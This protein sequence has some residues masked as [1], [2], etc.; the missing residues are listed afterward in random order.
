MCIST[1]ILCVSLYVNLFS[2]PVTPHT[3]STPPLSHGVPGGG[4][5]AAA[6]ETDP[7]QPGAAEPQQGPGYNHN[8]DPDHDYDHNQDYSH[9]INHDLNHNFH[10]QWSPFTSRKKTA[11]DGEVAAGASESLP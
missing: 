3:S 2:H 4:A 6:G 5:E 9:K 8:H 7:S 11:G 1:Y 10:N